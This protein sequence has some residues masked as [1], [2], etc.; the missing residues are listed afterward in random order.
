LDLNMPDMSGIEATRIIV[1]AKSGT[2][3][4]AL[5]MHEQRP[6]PRIMLNAGA[7]GF[8]G[9]SCSQQELILAIQTVARGRTYLQANLAQEMAI[10]GPGH[11]AN[12]FELCTARELD[13]CLGLA[14]GMRGKAL[15]AH[16]QISHKTV[17]TYRG[18]L[19]ERL[20]VSTE[21][22][23]TRL[24]LTHGLVP[25]PKDVQLDAATS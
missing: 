6:F 13:I 21:A 25:Y 5:T 20:G 10:G 7:R 14:N 19:F 11:G 3:I 18:R 1:A 4:L 8:L 23:L 15:G 17:A 9:K 16:L 22:E 2:R 24:A 12:P